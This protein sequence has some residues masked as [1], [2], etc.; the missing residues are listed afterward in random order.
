MI[1]DDYRVFKA[2]TDAFNES[3]S[4][5]TGLAVK[6]IKPGQLIVGEGE[7][8]L[9]VTGFKGLVSGS[10][11]LRSSAAA[12]LR[13][14]E[15][16]LGEKALSVDE[17]VL[18]GMKELSGIING[19]ASAKEQE[20]KLQFTPSLMLFI[21]ELEPHVSA[22]TLGFAVSYLVEQCGVFTIEIHHGKSA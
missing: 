12:V 8:F 17:S 16:Y 9:I 19:A 21:S 20:L 10:C 1:D 2:F 3:V 22:K 5:M 14:Y 18:D 6:R 11:Y 7:V 15:K 4:S 13:L